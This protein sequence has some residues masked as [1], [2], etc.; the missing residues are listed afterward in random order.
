MRAALLSEVERALTRSRVSTQRWFDE[1]S[2]KTIASVSVE[3]LEGNG[4]LDRR[5]MP[6]SDDEDRG[7]SGMNG[8]GHPRGIESIGE[9]G[10]AEA[11]K[12]VRVT[13]WSCGRAGSRH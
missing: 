13:G 10:P 9:I 7:A 6:G 11:G 3:D 12:C 8:S 1:D 4:L 5:G 2:A